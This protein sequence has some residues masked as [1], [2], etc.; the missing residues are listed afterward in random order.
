MLSLLI[1]NAYGMAGQPGGAAAGQQGGAGGMLGLFLP[2]IVV[3]GIFYL[4]M[5]RPQQK[6]AKK[7]KA[8]LEAVQRGDEVVTRSGI[9]GKVHGIADNVVTLEIADNVRIKMDKAQIGYVKTANVPTAE[10][11]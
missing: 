3:F 1:S 2:M 11:K 9:H 5:I 10:V 7:V 4:L 8:M 6:Q